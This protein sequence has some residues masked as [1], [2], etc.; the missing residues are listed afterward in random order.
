MLSPDVR[1]RPGRDVLRRELR[2]RLILLNALS[3]RYFEL[4]R[5]GAAIWRLFE[6]FGSMKAVVNAAASQHDGPAT[7]IENDILAFVEMAVAGNLLEPDT[8]GTNGSP[9]A[10]ATDPILQIG[11]S[12][13]AV[14]GTIAPLRDAFSRQHYIRLPQFIEPSLLAIVANRIEQGEFVDRTHHGIGKESCLVPGVATSALQFV[15]NDQRLLE[16]VGEIAGCGAVRSFDGR[17]YRMAP[18]TGHYDSWHSDAAEDR[19]VAVSVNLSREPY[20]G[21]VLEI[22]QASSTDQIEAVSN[23]GFGNAIMFR[24][25]PALRHRVTAVEGSE[26]RTAYA[27]WFRSAPDFQDLFLASL[28]PA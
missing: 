10:A 20:E 23:I 17:V 8:E 7:E 11:K 27:G 13:L 4:D 5:S 25:S 19:L 6:T 18:N 14:N 21:G 26:A 2:G 3:G 9:S 12:C 1:F 22:R 16:V 15:F 28:P 24:I